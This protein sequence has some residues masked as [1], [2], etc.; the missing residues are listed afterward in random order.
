MTQLVAATSQTQLT[1][2]LA[3]ANTCTLVKI[4]SEGEKANTLQLT[5]AV[6]KWAKD[7]K[8]VEKDELAPYQQNIAE[9]K[10]EFLP[11]HTRLAEVETNLKAALDTFEK[12]LAEERKKRL[13]AAAVLEAASVDSRVVEVV[14]KSAP[15]PFVPTAE[16]HYR[17]N[18]SAEVTDFKDFVHWCVANNRYDLL[19]VN[20]PELNKVA[21]AE[22]EKF[23]ISGAKTNVKETQ[24]I[25]S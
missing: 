17:K 24:I 6:K 7:I 10:A 22:K 11:I 3:F 20:Q 1:N 2:A 25:G 14:T 12:Q 16:L 21:I 9:I 23:N 5:K 4:T 15:A 19:Q 18:W 8:Q 13:A